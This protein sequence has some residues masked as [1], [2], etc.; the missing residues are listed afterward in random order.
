MEGWIKLHRKIVEDPVF[1]NEKL[2][3]VWLYCLLKASHKEREFMVG[4]QIV[5][6]KPGEFVFGRKKAAAELNMKEST[7]WD[8]IKLLE[9]LGNINIKSNNKFSIVNVVNWAKY[10]DKE[11]E[12]QQQ[13][14]QQIDNKPTTKQQQT[15]TNKNVK[16]DKNVKNEKNKDNTSNQDSIT[17][18]FEEV[19]KLY[20]KKTAKKDAFTAYKK[21]IKK[22]T[23]KEDIKKGV[24]N[25]V[26][27]FEANKNW[28]QPMDGGRWFVKERWNDQFNT[29][30][31]FKGKD[32]NKYDD[33]FL[34]E[35]RASDG[36][37]GKNKTDY[38][39]NADD[40]PF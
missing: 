32:I 12:V 8:R 11:T 29:D 7:V 19:W 14:Q 6:V 5:K 30:N 20:P 21:A 25:Y 38:G 16:K 17:H 37:T 23:L 31:N 33:P 34:N 26:R 35:R 10:Q 1:Q 28:L 18:S 3:K 27:Y 40:L 36:F 39:T 22:G 2:L 24:E 13:I 9:K 15:D 4:M